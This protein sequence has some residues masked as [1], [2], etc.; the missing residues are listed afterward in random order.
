MAKT[1]A[2]KAPGKRAG[3]KR[4]ARKPPVR[5]AAKIAPQKPAKKKDAPKPRQPRLP[6]PDGVP[7]ASQRYASLDAICERMAGR[8][9]KMADMKVDDKSDSQ[10]A[11]NFMLKNNVKGYKSHGMELEVSSGTAKL[12]KKRVS[13]EA[14]ADAPDEDIE[15][16]HPSDDEIHEEESF[17]ADKA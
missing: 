8:S 6:N 5:A 9:E 16:N 15:P 1:G 4:G 12:K 2:R 17:E 7:W 3:Q 11:L 13:D 14:T 10:D